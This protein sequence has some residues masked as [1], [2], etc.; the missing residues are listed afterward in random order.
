MSEPLSA[1]DESYK[2]HIQHVIAE[3]EEKRNEILPTYTRLFKEEKE[4]IDTTIRVMLVHHDLGKLTKRWQWRITEAI[5]RS[6]AHAPFGAAYVREFSLSD[7]L[8]NAAAFAIS[9]HHID[10]G[11][12]GA[13]IERPDAQAISQRVINQ[14][15]EIIW[16]AEA[17]KL[18]SELNEFYKL[19]NIELTV[20]RVNN[21][22]K[23]AQ[24]L[25]TWSRG[26]SIREIHRRRLLASAF[27]HILK[28]CDIRAATLRSEYNSEEVKH[29]IRTIVEGGLL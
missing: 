14:D 16:I 23:M 27:H 22:R 28:V 6:I 25:R 21:L 26:A 12:L 1:P 18:I 19:P 20:L 29:I 5:G 15:G 3:W 4:A 2:Q 7:D 24:D 10:R 11:I 8:K 13:N 9:I 17:D